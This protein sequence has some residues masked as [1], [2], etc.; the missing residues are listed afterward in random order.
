MSLVVAR[1]SMRRS[2]IARSFA[3]T[4]V[5]IAIGYHVAHYLTFLLVQGQYIIPLV[6][7]PFGYGWNLFGTAGYRVDIAL[8]GARFAWYAALAAILIGHVAA[9]YLAHRK[10]MALFEAAGSAL[11]SQVPLTALMVVYTFVS[12][13][14]LAEPIV[15]RREPAQ[16]SSAVAEVAVPADAVLPEPGSGAC[17]RSGPD[18]TRQGETDLPRA[19]LGVSRRHQDD[20][21][22]ISSM[23]P[24]SPIAGA[25]A[26]KRRRTTIPSST[27][28]PRRCAGIS[29]RCAWS[30]PTRARRA[31]ASATSISCA[32]FSSSRSTRRSRPKTRSRRRPVLPPWSTLPWHVLVLMEEAVSR[33][34]AAFSQAEA[35]RRGVEWLDLVRSEQTNA[36][37]AA[38][39]ETL[40]AR[41][42]SAG[43]VAVAGERGGGA[44]ALG[45]ARGV[46][47]EPTAIS[48]SPTAPTGSSA[49]P[50][51]ASPSK[52]SAT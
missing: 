3:F 38:L 37:L 40:R 51:T 24:C 39:V 29:S 48:W 33:G 41:R 5:P 15:E 6:S 21:A 44:Q 14:I 49:G 35:Q 16:P 36:K 12:L 10:A 9:V 46:L 18:K 43:A 42:I 52:R 1:G 47:Q 32:S 23:P 19:R 26:A 30:A 31:S 13:S 28:R 45:R 2:S 22:P 27:P 8:V 17:C 11:R 25:R 4:L 20:H 50:P 34:L 7:D